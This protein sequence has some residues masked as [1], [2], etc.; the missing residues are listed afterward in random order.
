MRVD[1]I[2]GTLVNATNVIGAGENS[3]ATLPKR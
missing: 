2:S 3:V 1:M